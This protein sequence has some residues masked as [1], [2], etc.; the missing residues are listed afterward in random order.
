[1]TV[2]ATLF[3]QM[4]AFAV[5]V[6]FTMKF[7]WPPISAAME[8]RKK[9]I[10]KGLAA[11]EQGEKAQEK[12]EAEAQE[13][14]AQARAQA[15]DIVNQA[16]KRGNDIVEEA[17]T[18]AVAEGERLKEAANAD[19]QAEKN[20]AKQELRGQV[21]SIAIAGAEKVLEREINADAHKDVLDK[22]VAQL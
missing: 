17:K 1:M 11:A 5:F 15:A 22:F 2:N 19:I 7:V 10:A 13:L 21:V 4:I 16:Q 8:E 20:K 14:L 6:L 18:T 9:T 12:A 3:A